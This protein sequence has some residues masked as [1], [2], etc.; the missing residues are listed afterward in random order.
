MHWASVDGVSPSAACR[1]ESWRGEAGS[2]W[3]KPGE[4][5]RGK[6]CDGS[7]EGLRAFPAAFIGGHGEARTGEARHGRTRPGL[8]RRCMAWRGKGH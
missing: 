6:G 4:V 8:A 3:V 5:R 1:G 7:K 2:G